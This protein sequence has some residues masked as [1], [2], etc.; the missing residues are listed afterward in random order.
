MNKLN[1]YQEISTLLDGRVAIGGSMSL[2]AHGDKSMPKNYVP[3]DIDLCIENENSMTAVHHYLLEQG[4]VQTLNFTRP[5][6]FTVRAQYVKGAEKRDFFIVPSL[7]D[8]YSTEI[9]GVRY[10][11]PQIIWT[12]RGFY[13]GVGSLKS[14]DQIVQAGM[15]NHYP[16]P[17][18][19]LRRVIKNLIKDIKSVL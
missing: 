16:R 13:A 17:G 12:A 6:M 3:G 9:D 4:Y 7:L 11:T 10:T 8:R 14:H 5:Y 2:I 1:F 19:T 15:C 18:M